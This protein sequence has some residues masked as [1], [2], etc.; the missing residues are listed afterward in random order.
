MQN[1]VITAL[2]NIPLF[3]RLAE[4]ALLTLSSQVGWAT[5]S[6]PP[7][8]CSVLNGGQKSAAHPILIAHNKLR[9]NNVLVVKSLR[10]LI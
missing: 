6:C 5:L 8:N 3:S 2:K 4:N 7:N 10:F 1:T 9:L